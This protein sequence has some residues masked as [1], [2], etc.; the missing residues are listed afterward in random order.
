MELTKDTVELEHPKITN[1]IINLEE[2]M[3]EL[4]NVL[5]LKCDDELDDTETDWFLYYLINVF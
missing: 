2:S 5:K 1:W 3:H 4:Y